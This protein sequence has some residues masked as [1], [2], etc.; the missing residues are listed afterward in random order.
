MSLNDDIKKAIQT[1]A[2]EVDINTVV[3]KVSNIDTTKNTCTCTPIDGTAEI[4]GVRLMAESSKGFLII[5]KNNSIVIVN[6]INSFTGY[7]SMFSEVDKIYLNGDTHSGLV[8]IDDL[9]NKLNALENLVNNIL[10]TLKTTTIP[11][12][13]SGTYPFAP[14]YTA[15]NNIAPITTKNDLENKNVLHG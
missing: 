6:M 1:L 11:L 3:C 14:L 9:V 8:K 15:I 5:P 4:L 7:V 13:P 12:A 2:G 10:N